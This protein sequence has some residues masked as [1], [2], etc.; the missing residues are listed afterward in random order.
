[1]RE[2]PVE[3]FF[4]N[5]PSV[6]L[7]RLFH[8]CTI[9]PLRL[10]SQGSQPISPPQMVKF[11]VSLCAHHGSNILLY[12]E[13]CY[14]KSELWIPN[15]RHSPSQDT[16]RIDRVERKHRSL[17]PYICSVC[18]ALTLWPQG[19]TCRISQGCNSKCKTQ[20][21][22]KSKSNIFYTV[23][24]TTVEVNQNKHFSH[25]SAHPSFWNE[26]SGSSPGLL[27]ISFSMSCRSSSNLARRTISSNRTPRTMSLYCH[28]ITLL[29]SLA[30]LIW[31]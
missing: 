11:G 7:I 4:V 27:L 5:L 18:S 25:F 24:H 21:F 28:F 30:Y 31:S 8:K 19:S 9:S 22:I 1:M 2:I 16:H 15:T 3:N 26:Q 29:L 20:I 23:Q 13:C 10:T 12:N 14:S 17:G 6:I